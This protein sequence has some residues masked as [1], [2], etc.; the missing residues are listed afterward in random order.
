LLLNEIDLVLCDFIIFFP[1]IFELA[2]IFLVN[3]NV[4]SRAIVILLVFSFKKNIDLGL[5]YF[6]NLIYISLSPVNIFNAITLP[7]QN[8]QMQFSSIFPFYFTS[9]LF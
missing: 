4:M 1:F 3:F 2:F 6:F 7:R 9:A 8:F 5:I